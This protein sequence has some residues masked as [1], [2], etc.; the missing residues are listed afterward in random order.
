MAWRRARQRCVGVAGSA[1]RQGFETAWTG[2]AVLRQGQVAKVFFRHNQALRLKHIERRRDLVALGFPAENNHRAVLMGQ[3][4]A[5][6]A[7]RVIAAPQ[8]GDGHHDRLQMLR[9]DLGGKFRAEQPAVKTRVQGPVQGQVL[10][11]GHLDKAAEHVHPI[12]AVKLEQPRA[13]IK[14]RVPVDA[15]IAVDLSKGLGGQRV[16]GE[17]PMQREGIQLRPVDPLGVDVLS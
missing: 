17:K 1:P 12:R 4:D 16:A 9:S 15:Q 13:Q 10:R 14:E 11:A 8:R 3:H 2:E 5:D 7:R 6:L